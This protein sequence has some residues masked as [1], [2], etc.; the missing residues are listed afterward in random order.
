M[1]FYNKVLIVSF[2]G[3][4]LVSDLQYSSNGDK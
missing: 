1:K 3:D 2:N 4:N